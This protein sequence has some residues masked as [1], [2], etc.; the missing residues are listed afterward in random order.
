MDFTNGTNGTNGINGH[1]TPSL[2]PLKITICGAGIGGLSA[3]IF[4]RQR[5]HTVT[6]LEASRFA[7]ELGAA[8]HLAPN[9]NGLLRRMG[10]VPEAQGA[11]ACRL[12]TQMLPN[13]KELFT[14]PLEHDAARWQH[15]WQLG[16]RVSLHSELK[17][18]AT[19]EEGEGKPAVLRLRAKVVDVDAKAGVVVLEDGEKIQSDV[20]VGADGVHSK[21]RPRIPGAENIKTFGSGKSAFRF[22]IPRQRA[23]D[24]EM[25]R[26]FAEKEGH[27]IM[28]FARDRRVVVY[29]TSNNTLLNFVC[30]HPTS[31]SQI[32][33]KEPGSSDWQNQ[34]NLNKML[35][36]YKDFEPAIL[37]LLGMAD[38][39]TLK[40][41]ELLDMDQLPT[42][43]DEKLVLIGDAAHPFTPHQGQGAGQAIE[44]AAS[45]AVMLPLGTPLDS[46]PARLKLYEKCR[47]ERAS[48]IQEY[49]RVAGKDL[50]SG[51]P[52]D[53]HKF[54]NYNFGHDEWD[55]S[56]Q[57]LRK[58]EWE[59]KKGLFWRMP[60]A[61][62][63]M[64]GPRQDFAGRPR[65]GSKA[66]FKTASIKFKTSR[67]VLE[68]LLPTEK[69]KFAA[70]DTAC[71]ASFAVT[72]LDNLEWLG[73]R[74]Y[75]HFGLYIHG[76]QHTKADGET[77]TGTYLPVLFENLADP[78]LSGR[79]EL[80]FP[81]LFA[82]LDVKSDGGKW[83]LDAGWMSSK[84]CSMSLSGLQEH[85]ATNGEA[86]RLSPPLPNDEGLLLHKYVPATGN[87][88]SKERGQA[89]VEYTAFLPGEEDAK[90]VEKKVERTLK[91]SSA[92]I[93]FDALDWKALPTLHHIVERLK[94]VP[95]YE[96]IEAKVVEGT[97]VSD[98]SSIRKLA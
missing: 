36:V 90:T 42:W 34:G 43:T 29:P 19:C 35:D 78:I 25:T 89:D 46:I 86:P 53:P 82:E 85:S 56:S 3:A 64:P 68:N 6:L 39:E 55:Y 38:E 58:W 63:P 8:V 76:I 71:Y 72:Q 62:G 95:V 77:V 60:T 21:T 70:A 7:N 5:G 66:T 65:D 93:S 54:T 96:V 22:L 74:G 41:W 14:V 27:L 52:V 50:G 16:H 9:A 10:M 88:G 49:S 20:V 67:T 2:R 28:I 79:E 59:N 37:K 4:L 91:A 61:F 83:T 17:R 47:Y 23:L 30:I 40:V 87:M 98:V 18:L 33:P 24:D 73:G 57:M 51:P 92:E 80:G 31:E 15:P 13:G 11:V 81:K 1:T 94:E 69:L 26:K 97:G 45:L 84:F 12:M 44:D 48:T 75:S 32:D